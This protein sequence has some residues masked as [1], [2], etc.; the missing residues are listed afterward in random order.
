MQEGT[1]TIG[2]SDISTNL[3]FV[4]GVHLAIDHHVSESIRNAENPKHIIDP[5]APSAARVV[6]NY[7][8]GEKR[9]PGFFEEM[10]DAVDKADSGQFSQDEILHPQGWALLNFLVDKRT[11]LEPWGKYRISEEQ[12]KLDLIDYCGSLT[13]EKILAVSD[14][15]ERA[16]IYF[17]YEDHY[18]K[19][20]NDSATVYHNI[21]ILDFREQKTIYPGNRFIVYGLFP[22]CNVSILIRTDF[23]KNKTIFS[24]GKSIL[25]RTS[26]VNIGELMLSNGG[27]GHRSA[28]ACHVDNHLADG[29][30]GALL[31]KLRDTI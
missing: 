9:F 10:M 13:I 11:N 14:I 8:G 25:N 28:G 17:T 7:F 4:Q 1:I 19:L 20:L 22:Q 26:E 30:F 24:V 29:V 6:F 12:F 3:P 5:N 15:K 21:A 2:A 18:K 23:E 16:D 27:G 31:E